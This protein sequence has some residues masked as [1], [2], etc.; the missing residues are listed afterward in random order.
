MTEYIYDAI[1]A[2]IDDDTK[3][4]I[5]LKTDVAGDYIKE[6][7]AEL[8]V[9]FADTTK[10]YEGKADA[11]TAVWTFI[12]PKADHLRTERGF[13]FVMLNGECLSGREP[14]YFR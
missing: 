9:E 5:T 2:T 12:I 4:E 7:K 11:E 8:V 10:T 13:Y 14:I 3:I 1:I 6:G